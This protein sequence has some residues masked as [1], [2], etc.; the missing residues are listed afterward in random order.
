LAQATAL[1]ASTPD[2]V[3]LAGDALRRYMI[4]RT[5]EERSPL[6]RHADRV[7]PLLEDRF[8]SDGLS[9]D[10]YGILPGAIEMPP[11]E[12]V[13][14]PVVSIPATV[15]RYGADR[16]APAIFLM[17]KSAAGFQFDWEASEPFSPMPLAAFIEER[18]STALVF[19]LTGRASDAY[20]GA[21]AKC[22]GTHLCVALLGSLGGTLRAYVRR[23]HKDAQLLTKL[24]ADG[25]ERPLTVA[26]RHVGPD[27]ES[28][29]GPGHDG[30]DVS[31]TRLV[32][33]S[34]VVADWDEF[35]PAADT[36]SV[37]TSDPQSVK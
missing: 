5:W 11:T 25:A 22:R 36:S 18:P 12:R 15:R 4:A 30:L 10:D 7:R 34:W 8:H 35:G 20:S 9:K 1:A 23:E 19:R 29:S 6:L 37:A 33:D 24:L 17:V 16:D 14:T 21:F 32:S 2:N 3:T 28:T 26:L 31:L 13:R 27:G